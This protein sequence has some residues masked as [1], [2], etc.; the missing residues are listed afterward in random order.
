MRQQSRRLWPFA[1]KGFIHRSRDEYGQEKRE[2]DAFVSAGSTGAILVGGQLI[3]G[4]I[5]GIERPP[6][7]PLI[8]KG[9]GSAAN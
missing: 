2:A 6:L 1:E 8:P 7:A 5:K 4:R 9:W 3:V